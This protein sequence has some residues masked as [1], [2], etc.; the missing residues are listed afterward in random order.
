MNRDDAARGTAIPILLADLCL[1][2]DTSSIHTCL[3]NRF[4]CESQIEG[5]AR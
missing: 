2:R 1:V 3:P 5:A 4:V